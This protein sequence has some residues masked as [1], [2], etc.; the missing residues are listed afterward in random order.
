MTAARQDT[1]GSALQSTCP[2]A[3]SVSLGLVDV[4]LPDV[5]S[6]IETQSQP[7][8]PPPCLGPLRCNS[9]DHAA[10]TSGTHLTDPVL[11]QRASAGGSHPDLSWWALALGGASAIEPQARTGRGREL[12]RHGEDTTIVQE[13]T[14]YRPFAGL[15]VMIN[16]S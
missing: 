6:Q 2:Y 16:S 12:L 14:V 8:R 11:G 10:A 7:T 13:A 4:R 1:T 15:A 3:L 9:V 5:A